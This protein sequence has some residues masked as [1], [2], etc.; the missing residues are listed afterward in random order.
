MTD[1]TLVGLFIGFCIGWYVAS[2]LLGDGRGV[3]PRGGQSRGGQQ[4]V[5]EG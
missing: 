4:Y 1:L 3:P 5:T 2:W